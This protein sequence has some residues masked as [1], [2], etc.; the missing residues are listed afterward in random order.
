MRRRRAAI[1]E[2]VPRQ[3][4]VGDDGHDQDLDLDLVDV[5]D[6]DGIRLERDALGA[7]ATMAYDDLVAGVQPAGRVLVIIVAALV[8]AM[9]V[10]A[11]AL[12]ERAERKPPGA[13]RD[14]SLAVWHPV[15]DVSHVLQLDRLRQVTDWAVGDD[16]REATTTAPARGARELGASGARGRPARRAGPR[17]RRGAGRSVRHT[18][19]SRRGLTARPQCA[20]PVR[21]AAISAR[22]VTWTQ[23]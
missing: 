9:L 2:R 22:L 17:R 20:A 11:D 16:D 21:S 1:D 14:R 23:S 19:R 3:H 10:N 6:P 12:V 15:Q 8:L 5:T 4:G 7:G 18:R 13:E